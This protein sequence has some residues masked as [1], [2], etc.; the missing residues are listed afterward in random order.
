M[1]NRI[2]AI[3]MTCIAI[4]SS[5]GQANADFILDFTGGS[6]SAPPL[7]QTLGWEFS[8]SDYK[9]ITGLGFWD[10]KGDGLSAD[11]MVGIWQVSGGSP[12]VATTVT[13][14]STPFASSAHEGRWLFQDFTTPLV[15]NPGI[16]VV[17][18]FYNGD[19]QPR[20]G[21]TSISLA[22][23]FTYSQARFTSNFVTGLTFPDGQGGGTQGFFGPN[24]M[25]GQAVPEPS[26]ILLS[27]TALGLTGFQRALRAR[28]QKKIIK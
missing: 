17:G 15:L 26:S 20:E 21:V 6:A 25:L 5:I 19:D 9:T 24:L 16:Y 2:L 11:H 1:F 10:E 3:A 8:L 4:M 7:M 23:G 27:I 12:L 28:R 14:T 13:N 22:P 18:A